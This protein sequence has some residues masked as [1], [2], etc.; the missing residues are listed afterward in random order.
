MP[1]SKPGYH[2]LMVDDSEDDY[3]IVKE[4]MAELGSMYHLD[5]ASSYDK[6]REAILANS[7]DLYMIDNVLGAGYG[8]DLIRETCAQGCDK[9][10]ILLTGVGNKQLDID[11]LKAGAA[12]FLVKDNLNLDGLE[13][14][15][16]HCLQR[17]E[18][19]RMFLE[20]QRLFRSFFETSIA[21]T[22]ILNSDF[23]VEESNPAFQNKFGSH[24]DNN[25][26]SA[27]FSDEGD[28]EKVKNHLSQGKKLENW[29][30]ILIDHEQLGTEVLINISAY[31]SQ[32]N[33]QLHYFGVINDITQMRKTEK[34]LALA[35]QVNMTGRM[36]RIMAHEI[37][38]PLTNINLAV[39]Q[40]REEFEEQE[41]TGENLAFI[42]LIK[43]NSQR[44]DNLITDL[45]NTTRETK[46]RK[47]END[48]ASIIRNALKLVADRIILKK[49]TLT[50][51]DLADGMIL[52]LD[53]ERLKIAFL[54]IFTNAIEAMENPEIRELKIS[55][56][57]N[58]NDIS[59]LIS[60]TGIGMTEEVKK[61]IFEPFYTGRS[62]GIGLGMTTVVNILTAHD[63]SI[64]IDSEP[65][66]GTRFTISFPLHG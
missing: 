44:I 62:G 31:H 34:Q 49:I 39:D 55:M 60:D 17:F 61:R 43:R 2:V 56:L 18:Y 4:I 28:F 51:D 52:A 12:D 53:S 15:L 65:G 58:E 63:A 13:R 38:N 54:N 20:Q 19:G 23:V 6:G 11:A 37:R 27:I 24:L 64:H 46:I 40:L 7:H 45:L 57:S 66:K 8:V 10:M 59:V 36:A 42:D 22:F 1:F 9:P 29:F 47:Q 41:V 48:L 50:V 14:S 16:R 35:E 30:T 26:V 3:L 32:Y 5:W 33:D 21:P 25:S